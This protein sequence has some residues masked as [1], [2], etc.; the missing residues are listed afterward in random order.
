MKERGKFSGSIESILSALA[1]FLAI[2][3]GYSAGAAGGVELW[4]LF[5]VL[6]ASTNILFVSGFIKRHEYR[7]E[8][9]LKQMEKLISRKNDTLG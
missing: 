4:W 1:L 5:G 8:Y 3:V 6:L 2:I 9:R 7:I